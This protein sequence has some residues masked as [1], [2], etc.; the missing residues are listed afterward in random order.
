MTATQFAQL[1]NARRIG[2]GKWM[3]RCPAHPDR[4]ASLAIGEGKSVPVLLRCMSAGCETK[5]ILDA[6]GLQWS[7]LMGERNTTVDLRAIQKERD[8]QALIE[9]QRKARYASLCQEAQWWEDQAS[10]WGRFLALHPEDDTAAERFH[11]SLDQIRHFN[12]QLAPF[13]HPLMYPS[14]CVQWKRRWKQ[15]RPTRRE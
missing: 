8:R 10:G 1:L 11:Y 13:R 2:K 12:A 6:M 14:E 5:A 3:A 7:D 4:N 15:I 9:L